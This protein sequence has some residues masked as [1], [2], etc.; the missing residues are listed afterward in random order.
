MVLDHRIVIGQNSVARFCT[1]SLAKITIHLC[2]PHLLLLVTQDFVIGQNAHYR[3]QKSPF[4]Y[5]HHTFC[6]WLPKI[7]NVCG[8]WPLAK[9][10]VRRLLCCQV[11]YVRRQV[12]QIGYAM[13]LQSLQ[14]GHLFDL[15]IHSAMHLLWNM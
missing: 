6:Y 5:V 12:D 13:I 1:L 2:S 15:F 11:V 14:Q 9:D 4:I 10:T 8:G 7:G 3:W